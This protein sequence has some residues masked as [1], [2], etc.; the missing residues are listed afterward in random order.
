MFASRFSLWAGGGQRGNP[1]LLAS[2]QGFESPAVQDGTHE[3]KSAERPFPPVFACRM[4]AKGEEPAFAQAPQIDA[5]C[6]AAGVAGNKPHFKSC[7]AG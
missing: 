2:G 4:A 1:V 3:P 6:C 7:F 5:G